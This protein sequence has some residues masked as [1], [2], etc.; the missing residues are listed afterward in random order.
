MSTNTDFRDKAKKDLERHQVPAG[1]RPEETSFVF[2]TTE[3]WQ[4]ADEWATKQSSKHPWRSIV[5]FDATDLQ[6]WVEE[7]LSVQIWL[8][9][10]MESYREGFQSLPQA[11]REWGSVA[12]PPLDPSLLSASVERHLSDWCRWVQST[13]KEPLTIIG[14]SKG[15]VL[16]FVQ[17]LIDHG[18]SDRPPIPIEG[19]CVSTKDGIRLLAESPLSDVV[20]IPM[21]EA[22]QEVA[23]AHSGQLRVV[24]P[25]T[26]QPRVADPIV[27]SSAGRE[28][29][30]KFLIQ[31]GCDAGR[32]SQ[33]ARSSGG[34][35]SVLAD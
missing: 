5:V 2:V 13:G 12:D 9:D 28:Q 3:S 8:M 22:V 18:R 19:L 15:E 32:A 7:A 17:A 20:V 25:T 35:I 26:G 4:G 23:V 24:L 29:V 30:R 14:E 27:V 16:L 33:L 10:R 11:V 31:K 21:D 6:G 1:W 34:S